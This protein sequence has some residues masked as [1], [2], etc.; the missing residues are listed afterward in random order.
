MDNDFPFTCKL[1]ENR[2]LL[3]FRL[4]ERR[5]KALLIIL[6]D[7]FVGVTASNLRGYRKIWL[8]FLGSCSAC[9]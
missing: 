7:G 2:L 6:F 3:V 8:R 9:V 4:K 5:S 1:K